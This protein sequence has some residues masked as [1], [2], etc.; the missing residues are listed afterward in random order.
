MDPIISAVPSRTD[1]FILPRPPTQILLAD[2]D[3]EMRSMI[4]AELRDDGYDVVEAENGMDLVRSAL[5]FRT[6]LLPFDLLITDVR[7]PGWNGL[8]ALAQL[9]RARMTLPVIVMT[10]F[11]DARLHTTA[12]KLGA[13]LVFD[14]PFDLDDLSAAVA[15]LL[16]SFVP[17]SLPP[18]SS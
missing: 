12:E 16:M 1:Y 2:D 18:T 3:L 5:H 7:M 14:K 8:E 11:G 6:L 10:A 13:A 9:R 17:P 15:G 4:A